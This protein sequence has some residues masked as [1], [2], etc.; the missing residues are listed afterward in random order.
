MGA[1]LGLTATVAD[2]LTCLRARAKGLRRLSKGRALDVRSCLAH[3][4]AGRGGADACLAAPG[5][6]FGRARAKVIR[7]DAT[8]C[9]DRSP[10]FGWSELGTLSEAS[11]REHDELLRDLLGADLES[12]VLSKSLRPTHA[13][14]QK[15]FVAAAYACATAHLSDFERCVKLG[16]RKG[17]MNDGADLARCAAAAPARKVLRRCIKKLD[18]RAACAD[19][20]SD[21]APGCEG[22]NGAADCARRSARCR[23]CR[24][25]EDSHRLTL[26]CDLVDDRQRNASCG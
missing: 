25:I 16:A 22:S 1:S 26:D 23:A 15:R 3:A 11:L 8:S 19:T 10:S 4:A 2:Q 20:L 13:K 24:D 17:A 14:C 7:V 9:E 18:A 5:E 21:V 12:G 6:R